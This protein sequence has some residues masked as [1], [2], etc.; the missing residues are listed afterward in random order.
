[1][2]GR[3]IRC[4]IYADLETHCRECTGISISKP[5]DRRVGVSPKYRGKS[6]PPRGWG[7]WSKIVCAVP[8]CRYDGLA[9]Y[10]TERQHSTC[11]YHEFPEYDG[12]LGDWRGY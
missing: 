9:V 4:S 5:N 7:R 12:K 1:M 11:G 6:L 10:S 8:V 3:T 2:R